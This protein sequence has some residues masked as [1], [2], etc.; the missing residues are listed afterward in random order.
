MYY[1]YCGGILNEVQKAAK[2]LLN[3]Y[4][5]EVQIITFPTL[6]PIDKSLIMDAVMH[7]KNI[8]T[9]EEHTLDGGLG[10][11]ISEVIT[12]SLHFPRKI[13]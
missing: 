13:S 5:I 7:T 1:F 4:L 3:K 6:K 9:V 8:I 2:I 12:Y 11:I 10:S